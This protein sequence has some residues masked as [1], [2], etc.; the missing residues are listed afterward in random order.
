MIRRGDSGIA[1]ILVLTVLLGLLVLAAPFLT[2]AMNDHAVSESVIAEGQA[3][4]GTDALLKYGAWWLERTT[5]FGEQRKGGD[6]GSDIFSTPDWDTPEEFMVPVDLTGE[7]GGLLTGADGLMLL[8]RRDPR[9]EIWDL[10]VRDEQS[11]PNVWSAPPFLLAASL[12]RTVHTQEL[13]PDDTEIDLE[14]GKDFPDK[15]GAIWIDG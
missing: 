2:V 9:G 6:P 10:R 13:K 4:A 7:R 5:D 3:E 1:F 15:N 14:E 11:V 12:G 8:S